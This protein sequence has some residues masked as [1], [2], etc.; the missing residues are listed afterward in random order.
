MKN[1]YHTILSIFVFLTLILSFNIS[2]AATGAP[3]TYFNT[4]YAVN[5]CGPGS[6]L[7]E[8]L[9]PVV[10]GTNAAGSTFDLGSISAGESAGSLGN[11]SNANMG[12]TYSF[13]QV[14][15]S[16]AFTMTGTVG[17]CVTKTGAD[18]NISSPSAVAGAAS[19]TA[20]P[21][22]IGVPTGATID[23]NMIG[24]TST[25]GIN[26]A[27]NTSGNGNIADAE[28]N[29]K[30]RFAI[31]EPFTLRTGKLPTIEIAFDLSEGI[32]FSSDCTTSVTPGPPVVS[33]TFK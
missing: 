24:T 30:F 10:L 5:L 15:L 13:A 26:G 32:S 18:F 3:A 29:M 1:T 8:C 21:Q 7:T 31:A 2:K 6:S 20:V 16:R 28:P 23:S 25:N 22:V 17:S 4:I 19:G 12:V 27:D 11:L 14:V 9:D 33:V